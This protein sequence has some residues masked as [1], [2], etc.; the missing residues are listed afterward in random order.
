MKYVERGYQHRL[1]TTREQGWGGEMGN[2]CLFIEGMDF[3]FGDD[4]VLGLDYGEGW[5]TLGYA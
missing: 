3:C 1:A 4:T 5:I 2:D